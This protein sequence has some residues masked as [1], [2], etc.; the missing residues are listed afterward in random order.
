MLL[1]DRILQFMQ[2]EA[3]KPLTA[4]DLAEEM[5]LKGKAQNIR[6]KAQAAY[7]DAKNDIKKAIAGK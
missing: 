4:E 7:G 2:E 5:E 3:Y 1:K 6:G